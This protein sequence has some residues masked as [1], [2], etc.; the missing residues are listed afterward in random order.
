VSFPI[1]TSV[2][3]TLTGFEETRQF[4]K[5]QAGLIGSPFVISIISPPLTTELLTIGGFISLGAALLPT[6]DLPIQDYKNL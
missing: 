4:P 2:I 1:R 5:K 3:G 6:A